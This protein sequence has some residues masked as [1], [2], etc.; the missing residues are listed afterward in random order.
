MLDASAIN[1]AMK[2]DKEKMNS[3]VLS[4]LELAMVE[5]DILDSEVQ[6]FLVQAAFRMMDMESAALAKAFEMNGK[7]FEFYIHPF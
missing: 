2:K 3:N 6:R 5:I 4:Q 7:Q 1:R